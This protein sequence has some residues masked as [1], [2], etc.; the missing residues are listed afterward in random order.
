MIKGILLI[1]LAAS[2]S[3]GLAVSSA[4]A[5]PPKPWTVTKC[6][7]ALYYNTNY[8]ACETVSGQGDYI[9]YVSGQWMAWETNIGWPIPEWHFDGFGYIT[10]SSFA[11]GY[12]PLK[13]SGVRITRVWWTS[14]KIYIWKYVKPHSQICSA[15]RAG[16]PGKSTVAA[17]VCFH[18]P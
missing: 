16:V 10:G 4:S 2:L 12:G 14:P 3:I 9:H 1:A 13:Y 15:L 11:R 6:A 17:L 5:D 8:R 18:A 7:P